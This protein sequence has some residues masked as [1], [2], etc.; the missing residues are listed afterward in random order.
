MHCGCGTVL[1]PFHY[2]VGISGKPE[3]ATCHERYCREPG[4]S[5]RITSGDVPKSGYNL[6]AH[7]ERAREWS[8]RTFGPG[9]RTGGVVAHIRKELVEVEESRGLDLEEW[10]DVVILALDGA[11]R[12]GFTP[13]QIA[14]ALEA[15]QTKNEG[16]R[17][18]D[19]RQHT[20][21]QPIEH[22]R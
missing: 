12:A 22:V 15:K 19:W 20:S 16:R 18:P 10:V 8:A 21:D 6:V 2:F 11:W 1:T 14:S 17:W 4:C 3:C 9:D 7:V 5:Y 13:E